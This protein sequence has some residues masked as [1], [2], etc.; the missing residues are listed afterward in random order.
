MNLENWLF[1]VL[2]SCS[3]FIKLTDIALNSKAIVFRFSRNV[4]AK[5]LDLFHFFP[6]I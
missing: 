4:V 5:T 2:G 6:E 1:K 3:S